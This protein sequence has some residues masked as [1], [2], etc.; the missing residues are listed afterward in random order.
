[1]FRAKKKKNR[2][3]DDNFNYDLNDELTFY[4]SNNVFQENKIRKAIINMGILLK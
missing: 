4:D 1:M 3:L 2:D